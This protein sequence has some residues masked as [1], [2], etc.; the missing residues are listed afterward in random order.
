[1]TLQGAAADRLLVPGGQ[2][3]V[4]PRRRELR[5]RGGDAERRI[6]AGFE[7]GPQLLEVAFETISG[8][9]TGGILHGEM[10]GAAAEQALNRAHGGEQGRA[11]RLREGGE[12]RRGGLVR[13]AIQRGQFLAAGGGERDK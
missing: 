7:P 11:L 12:E 2:D 3:E 5:R 1:M 8:G 13:Q 10:D 9:R 6:V 4:A